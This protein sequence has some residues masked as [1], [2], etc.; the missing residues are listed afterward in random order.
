MDKRQLVGLQWSYLAVAGK[1][2]DMKGIHVVAP[3]ALL[4]LAAPYKDTALCLIFLVHIPDRWS[5]VGVCACAAEIFGWLLV[6]LCSQNHSQTA[7]RGSATR[8]HPLPVMCNRERRHSMPMQTQP[9]LSDDF[10][11]VISASN[12]R[13][14]GESWMHPRAPR[15]LSEPEVSERIGKGTHEQESQ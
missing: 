13:V 15:E 14:L 1:Q 12:I 3:P 11:S 8:Q 4:R 5:S 2:A 7:L 6:K 9:A 10:T